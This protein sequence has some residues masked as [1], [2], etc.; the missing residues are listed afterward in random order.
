MYEDLER[1]PSFWLGLGRDTTAVS[2]PAHPSIRALNGTEESYER[3]MPFLLAAHCMSN[4][5]PSAAAAAAAAAF[6]CPQMSRF[7]SDSIVVEECAF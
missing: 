4:A 6:K 1:M 7:R 3:G 5:S 2:A